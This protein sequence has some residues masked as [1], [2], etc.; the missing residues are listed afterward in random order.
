M[1]LDLSADTVF[2]TSF[3]FLRS[4]C[5]DFFDFMNIFENQLVR[6]PSFVLTVFWCSASYTVIIVF[7]MRLMELVNAPA[8]CWSLA[9]LKSVSGQRILEIFELFQMHTCLYLVLKYCSDINEGIGMQLL[10]TLL[11]I[12]ENSCVV[13][14][15]EFFSSVGQVFVLKF[16]R[17]AVLRK[18]LLLGSESD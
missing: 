3:P 14:K 13:Y 8:R 16:A 2:Q 4:Y 7:S 10:F 5:S 11:F 6:F 9:C 18:C 1:L 17:I 12:E 15:N